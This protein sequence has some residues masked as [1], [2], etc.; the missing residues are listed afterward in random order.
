[1]NP[2]E[3][4]LRGNADLIAEANLLN[5]W[6]W[7]FTE[8]CDD[9][10][11]GVFAE[12]MVRMLLGLPCASE[13]RVSWANSDII[14][15][16]GTRIEVKSSAL[17][18]AYK[19]FDEHGVRFADLSLAIKDP[20]KVRFGRLRARNSLILA[21]ETDPKTF[22]SDLYVFCFQA[23]PD[24]AVW[25]AWDLS[26]WEFYVMSRQELEER[27]IGNSISLATLRNM[28]PSMSACQFQEYASKN[29]LL[30]KPTATAR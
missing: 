26:Q 24:P 5:F 23:Q 3:M 6:Q 11:R 28:R 14:L 4:R 18:E 12:W 21:P 27:K 13:Q 16:N 2:E 19:T 1:M 29:L 17:V 7:A 20:K 9:S 22:K 10:T 8:M 25:D 15:E 30:L